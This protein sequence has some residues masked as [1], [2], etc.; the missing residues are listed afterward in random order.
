MHSLDR[1][2]AVSTKSAI[3]T[4]PDPWSIPCFFQCSNTNKS[5]W[6]VNDFI[7]LQHALYSNCFKK[8]LRRGK[9]F[10]LKCAF[11]LVMNTLSNFW[12]D[13]IYRH[14]SLYRQ[15]ALIL[16]VFFLTNSLSC[17]FNM[18]Y[19]STLQQ[20]LYSIYSNSLCYN[21]E[22][23]LHCT[24]IKWLK[25]DNISLKIINTRQT[26]WEVVILLY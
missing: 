13:F 10:L 4:W 12:K 21:H 9:Y 25:R 6:F 7:Q 17:L 23:L 16:V 20:I 5:W 19:G 11:K 15:K 24:I 26:K 18:V 22:R 8:T 14:A 2:S 1:I 3:T